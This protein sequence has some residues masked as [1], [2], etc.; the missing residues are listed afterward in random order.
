MFE[1]YDEG[2]RQVVVL[3]QEEALDLGHHE[4]GPLHQLLA[5]FGARYVNS[6]GRP[7]TLARRALR[8][9]GVD[10]DVVRRHA[11]AQYAPPLKVTPPSQMLF[12]DDAK[13][14]LELAFREALS[15]GHQSIRGE[16]VLMALTRIEAT[17]EVLP[18]DAVRAAIAEEWMSTFERK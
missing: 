18:S 14:A 10:E 5:C 1:R 7:Y 8:Q 4:I 15:S 9:A 11:K 2:A 3:A 6:R 16:H 13:R 17:F 12:T